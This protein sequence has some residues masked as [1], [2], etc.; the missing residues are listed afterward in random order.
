MRELQD[1]KNEL[2]HFLA[3]NHSVLGDRSCTSQMKWHCILRG[4]THSACLQA[5]ANYQSVCELV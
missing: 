3:S 1:D 5:V 2:V 4:I